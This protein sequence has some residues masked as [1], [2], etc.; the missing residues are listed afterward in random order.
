MLLLILTEVITAGILYAAGH[1]VSSVSEK[2]SS[3]S[4]YLIKEGLLT[5]M[6]FNAFNIAFGVGVHFQYGDRNHEMYALSSVA[7]V[8]ASGLLFA[9]CILLMFADA[10]Q[11]GEF[12]DK[13]KPDLMSQLY[14]VFSL[15]YR[16]ALGYYI[17]VQNEY[18]LSSLVIVGF[19]MLFILYNLVNLPFN[20]AYHN[21]RAN[22]CH[23]AQ[24]IILFV[25]NY[26]DSLSENEPWETKGYQYSAAEIQIAAIYAAVGLSAA[27]LVVDAYK[28]I[29]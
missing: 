24:L 28:L 4:K 11:F 2:L 16:F 17:A 9:T 26:Y 1:L 12:K 5:L 15:A 25:T 8:V 6:M 14:F 29:K 13:F 7:A 10:K 27:C 20:D 23:F 18:L 22:F 21:Y 3:I 19:S